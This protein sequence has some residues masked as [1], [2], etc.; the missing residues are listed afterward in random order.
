MLSGHEEFTSVQLGLGQAGGVCSLRV[1]SDPRILDG[2]LAVSIAD[3]EQESFA[4][5]EVRLSQSLVILEV[6]LTPT[7]RAIRAENL[8][9]LKDIYSSD[10][11]R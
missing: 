6:T 4:G 11:N 7:G 8:Q 5:S 9:K 10:M 3:L 1:Q 2:S